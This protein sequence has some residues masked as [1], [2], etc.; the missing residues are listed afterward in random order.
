MGGKLD[1]KVALILGSAGKNNMGQVMAR[2]FKEE[3]AEV[4]VAGRNED[5][6]KEISDEINGSYAICD[7]TKKEDIDTMV[8]TVVERHGK[9]S[10][11]I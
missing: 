3:G 4:V 7:I 9:L 1:G 6:L 5:S 11:G 8:S 2:R 10:I